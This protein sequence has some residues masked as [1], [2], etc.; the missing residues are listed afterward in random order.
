MYG[1]VRYRIT[2][3][4]FDKGGERDW[5]EGLV[6]SIQGGGAQGTGT[7]PGLGTLRIMPFHKCPFIKVPNICNKKSTVPFVS[8]LRAKRA[9]SFF[10]KCLFLGT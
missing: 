9:L 6:V 2:A 4:G 1:I 7:L 5:R 3:I 10:N 8:I